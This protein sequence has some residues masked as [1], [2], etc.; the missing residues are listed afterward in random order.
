[1]SYHPAGL[2]GTSLEKLE[3][4]YS[5]SIEM[6]LNSFFNLL[7]EDL[8]EALLRNADLTFACKWYFALPDLTRRT[9]NLV[10]RNTPKSV[11][12]LPPPPSSHTMEEGNVQ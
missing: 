9:S 7:T 6:S 12:H 5:E 1:M 2:K 10:V 11:T 3:F 4:S 8:G